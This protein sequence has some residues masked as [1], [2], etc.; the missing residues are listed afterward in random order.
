MPVASSHRTPS[1]KRAPCAGPYAARD[2]PPCQSQAERSAGCF[3]VSS[4]PHLAEKSPMEFTQARRECKYLTAEEEE[5]V[6]LGSLPSSFHTAASS[7]SP[8]SSSPVV[9]HWDDMSVDPSASVVAPAA[10]AVEKEHMF[11][12]VVTPSDVG[13]LNRLVIPKQHAEKYFP[14]DASNNDKGLLLNF[15]DRNGKPWRFRYSYWNSSQSY[16]M[17]KGWSRFVKEKQLDAGDTVTF[18]R[19]IGDDFRDRL[20][21]DWKRRPD[22][23]FDLPASLRIPRFTYHPYPS[24]AAPGTMVGNHNPYLPY[25]PRSSAAPWVSAGRFFVPNAPSSTTTSAANYFYF[26]SPQPGQQPERGPPIPMVLDSFPVAHAKPAGAPKRVRLF[27]VNL[28]QP[29]DAAEDHDSNNGTAGLLQLQSSRT[30]LPSPE[31]RLAGNRSSSS[32]SSSSR[33]WKDRHL[34]P[35]LDLDK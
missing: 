15:E 21:I 7:S 27:G 8:S 32:S 26:R 25:N 18:G 28:E 29:C 17:T 2:L 4:G 10:T 3:G 23:R 12:K 19:G 31:L 34:S 24:T 20:F 13:K 35:S 33:G 30:H 14:L 1:S 22:Q 16:V 11:E 9:L 6:V 5:R